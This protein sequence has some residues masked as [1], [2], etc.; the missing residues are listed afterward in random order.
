MDSPPLPSLP[1][2]NFDDNSFAS[3]KACFVCGA[4][5]DGRII[6]PPNKWMCDTLQGGCSFLNPTTTYFCEVCDRS[7]P[8]LAS[9]RF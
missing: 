5:K 9:V 6:V 1:F 7:R 4:G 8:S 2:P 3:D